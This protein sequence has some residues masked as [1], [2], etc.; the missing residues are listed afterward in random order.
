MATHNHNEIV[1][2]TDVRQKHHLIPRLLRAGHNKRKRE[3]VGY[4]VNRTWMKYRENDEWSYYLGH[5]CQSVPQEISPFI[6][7]VVFSASLFRRA[8]VCS[9]R[10]TNVK[11]DILNPCGNGRVS[12]H[13]SSPH[14]NR[15]A[16]CINLRSF[17][18]VRL[19]L[20]SS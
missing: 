8:S 18:T 20:R 2:Q 12:R 10:L 11:Y 9:Y 1:R 17:A 13:Q 6:I 3:T 15:A 19:G 5:L 16:S 7:C 4:F 14:L